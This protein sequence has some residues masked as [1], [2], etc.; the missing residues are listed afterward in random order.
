MQVSHVAGTH[1]DGEPQH[2]RAGRADGVIRDHPRNRS[3][4]RRKVRCHDGRL[5][6]EID[7]SPGDSHAMKIHPLEDHLVVP[8]MHGIQQ[9]QFTAIGYTKYI[10]IGESDM[11]RRRIGTDSASADRQHFEARDL[12][13][14]AQ[15]HTLLLR[16]MTPFGRLELATGSSAHRPATEGRRRHTMAAPL[17][18]DR[19]SPRSVD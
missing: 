12:P 6:V 14:S 13:A 9:D 10:E 19:A 15:P 16:S 1:I 2:L 18:R 7:V 17:K 8:P 3:A 5:T 11:R 4:V